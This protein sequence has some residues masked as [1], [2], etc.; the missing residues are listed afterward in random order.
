MQERT[1]SSGFP[2]IDAQVERYRITSRDSSLLR[3]PSVATSAR[4]DSITPD[5]NY[6]DQVEQRIEAA[7]DDLQAAGSTSRSNHRRRRRPWTEEETH[8]LIGQV[9]RHGP[10]WQKIWDRNRE[11]RRIIDS[12]RSTV[13]YKDK[14]MIYKKDMLRYTSLFLLYG[15]KANTTC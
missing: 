11:G 5:G 3:L 7:I 2:T 9:S 14:A 6:L 12:R 8:F 4:H 1:S 15:T 13:D 10:A